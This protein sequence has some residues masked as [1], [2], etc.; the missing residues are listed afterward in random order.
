[1]LTYGPLRHRD[2]FIDG[3]YYIQ[4]R[5]GCLLDATGGIQGFTKTLSHRDIKIV[6]PP[7]RYL[8]KDA[9]G[10]RYVAI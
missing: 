2:V 4:Q 8:S 9:S 1:M 5:L 6:K 7:S 3:L 10:F